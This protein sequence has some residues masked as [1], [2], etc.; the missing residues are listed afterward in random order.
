MRAKVNAD[1]ASDT[2]TRCSR[3]GFLVYLNC[4]PIYGWSKKKSS[5]ESLFCGSEFL[6]MK[7][8]CEY[9]HGL[10]DKLR[11]MGIL[12]DDPMFIYGDHHSVLGNT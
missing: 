11:M 9:F 3:T 12:C 10:R 4:A 1:H 5:V 6:A 2:I 7:Q 8:C